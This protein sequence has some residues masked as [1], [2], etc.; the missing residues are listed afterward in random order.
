MNPFPEQ[1]VRRPTSNPF[2][3]DIMIK[4]TAIA[5]FLAACLL[6]ALDSQSSQAQC[7]PYQ[8]WHGIRSGNTVIAP[9]PPYFALHPPVYYDRVVPRAIGYSP[10]AVPPGVVPA[11]N[12]VQVEPLSV[13]NPFYEPK[14]AKNEPK[15]MAKSE[16]K[17]SY[18]KVTSKKV[19]NPFYLQK[20]VTTK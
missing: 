17:K 9:R 16:S 20:V 1:L 4:K 8:G 5:F 3:I 6:V 19:A 2:W 12:S 18:H 7:N 14:A 10:F 15:N 13:M 11:E